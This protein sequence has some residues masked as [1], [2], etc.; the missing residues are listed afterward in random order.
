MKLLKIARNVVCRYLGNEDQVNF[1]C[2]RDRQR[3]AFEILSKTTYG[4]K[5]RA[6]VGVDR[7]VEE[8]VFLAAFPLHDVSQCFT[9]MYKSKLKL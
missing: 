7:M 5:K 8:D 3:V 1:F 6:E 2:N 9:F 4:K